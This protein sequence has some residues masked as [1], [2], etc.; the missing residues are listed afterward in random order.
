M[1]RVAA[2][3]ATGP[4]PS[5]LLPPPAAGALLLDTRTGGFMPAEPT[6][7][8]EAALAACG[9]G[10][11]RPRVIFA[12]EEH[13]N[14]LQHAL[15]LELIKA[16]DALDSAPTL[17]GLEMCWR[18]HQPALDAF[19]FGDDA[20]GGGN[21]E[22]L[23]RRTQWSQT[24]GYPIDLY[25]D[26]LLYARERRLRLCGLNTPYPV[27]RAVSRVGLQQLPQELRAFLP[28]V[29]LDNR[30]HKLRFV[31]A[32]GGTLALDGHARPP[33]PGSAAEATHGPMDA[34]DLE[35]MYEA[36][37]LWDDFMASSIAG[38]VSAE[39][40]SGAGVDGAPS[41]GDER[42]VVLLGAGHV[43][44]RVG[45]PDRYTKRTQLPT[46][47]VLPIS[48]PWPTTDVSP[49]RSATPKLPASEA[50]W[51]VYTRPQAPEGL[52]LVSYNRFKSFS[53]WI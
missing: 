39:A 8:L 40:K 23:A 6:R 2:A 33:A 27:V 42:M 49:P 31:Q 3:A 21:V 29:D 41:R 1:L 53:R 25:T 7:Y 32:M 24:W 10:A 28:N 47:T 26:V 52:G 48:V 51:V 11:Q 5:V 13:T 38:Y 9:D 22:A 17:I 4:P 44:G 12:G 50:D 43:R 20:R 16:V 34:E 19:I 14:A 35:R 36:F 46:F 30:E 18:Q 15:Q 45:V 37:A